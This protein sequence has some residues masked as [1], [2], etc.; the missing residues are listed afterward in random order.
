MGLWLHSA[1]PEQ[2]YTP[3]GYL[4]LWCALGDTRAV[5]R[6][7]KSGMTGSWEPRQMLPSP[8]PVYGSSL[9][10]LPQPWSSSVPR[11]LAQSYRSGSDIPQTQ[12]PAGLDPSPCFRLGM[13]TRPFPL[14]SVLCCLRV[15]SPVV[16][17]ML[18]ARPFSCHR[19]CW[20]SCSHRDSL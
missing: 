10:P 1:M 3:N 20:K 8:S 15:L 9:S 18:L 5:A 12:L 17:I 7:H 13:L 11:R 14:L 16:T 6:C 4:E 2:S 19:Y